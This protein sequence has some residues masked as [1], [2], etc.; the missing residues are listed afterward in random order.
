MTLQITILLIVLSLPALLLRR[1]HN[2]WTRACTFLVM[3]GVLLATLDVSELFTS[4]LPARLTVVTT[5]P[6]D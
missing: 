2:R 5:G 1:G 3:L 4:H 6:A